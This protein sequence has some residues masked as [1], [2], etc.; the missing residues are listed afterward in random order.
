MKKFLLAAVLIVASVG[1]VFLQRSNTTPVDAAFTDSVTTSIKTSSTAAQAN[2]T[3]STPTSKPVSPTPV[4]TKPKH[5]GQYSDGTYT[6]SVADA[7][8]GNIQVAAV[9][10]GGKLTN[11]KVLQYPNDRDTS[12]EINQQALPMLIREAI[13]AQNANVNAI[14]GASDTSPAFNQSLA[15]ALAKAKA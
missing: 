4:A 13:S 8:Y 5:A 2:T 6:G 1:Y 11:V 9:I 15:S 12:V 14:S 10:S 7:Y 3:T